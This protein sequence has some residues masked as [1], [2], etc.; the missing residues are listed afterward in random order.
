MR[1]ISLIT[2]GVEDLARARAF[3]ADWLGWTPANGPPGVYFYQ[4]GGMVVA[5]WPRSDLVAD[6]RFADIAPQDGFGG[7]ALAHNV[8]EKEDVARLLARA[9]ELGGR[10]LKP[11]QDTSWGG[12][13]G[14]VTDLDGHVWEVGWNPFWKRAEDGAV[15][16]GD[17]W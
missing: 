6:A 9:A 16:M 17:D 10:I 13:S 1:R 8:A 7:I 3:Y 5:L 11:A 4:Q 12:H 2:I 15:T 14:Y